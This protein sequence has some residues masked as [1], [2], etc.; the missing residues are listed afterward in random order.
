MHLNLRI[1]LVSGK[2][3]KLSHTLQNKGTYS[4][5]V[6]KLFA[7]KNIV[8]LMGVHLAIDLRLNYPYIQKVHDCF[9]TKW[10][11]VKDDIAKGEY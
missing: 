11:E 5:H 3:E 2:D 4:L 9:H 10:K 7:S 8:Q 1:F 6:S